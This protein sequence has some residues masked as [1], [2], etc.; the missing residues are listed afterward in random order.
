MELEEPCPCR[1][2]SGVLC[3]RTGTARSGSSRPAATDN[4]RC[5]SHCCNAA[6]LPLDLPDQDRASSARVRR[7]AAHDPERLELYRTPRGIRGVDS[8]RSVVANG[9]EATNYPFARLAPRGF[10]KRP[11]GPHRARPARCWK[12]DGCQQPPPKDSSGQLVHPTFSKT[13]TRASWGY[14]LAWRSPMRSTAS[15]L[16]PRFGRLP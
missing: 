12:P 5:A 7:R 15:R 6:A 9:V 1:P 16:R 13:G 4:A 2:T 11:L 14:R 10:V 8:L 3:R